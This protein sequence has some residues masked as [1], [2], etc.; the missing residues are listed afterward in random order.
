MNAFRFISPLRCQDCK[1]RFVSRTVFFED[2]FYAHCPRCDRLDLNDWSPK[3]NTP[4]A[5]TAFK[6]VM[7]A[8]R[9]R[10]EYCRLNFASFRGRKEVFS[11]KRWSRLNPERVA[12]KGAAKRVE[13]PAIFVT[14]K[15]MSQAAG[16][17]IPTPEPMAEERSAVT[18]NRPAIL[19]TPRDMS[20]AAGTEIPD[21]P[22][23]TSV[24]K[25]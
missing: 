17:E 24:K 14:S 6:I 13:K 11:F 23:D 5:W 4:S 25:K 1:T 20:L 2:L 19:I 12:E 9:W 16:I 7:G 21:G 8:R 3:S 15:D 18:A 10:C 22:P